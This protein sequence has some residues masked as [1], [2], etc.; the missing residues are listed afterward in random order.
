M[1]KILFQIILFFCLLIPTQSQEIFHKSSR[2]SAFL[3]VTINSNVELTEKKDIEYKEN[4]IQQLKNFNENLHNLNTITVAT[5]SKEEIKVTDFY[6]TNQIIKAY[7]GNWLNLFIAGLVTWLM[8]LLE[9]PTIL[10][11]GFYNKPI[12]S[13][14]HSFTEAVI[15]FITIYLLLTL[16]FNQKFIEILSLFKLFG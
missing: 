12:R 7:K 10:K 9:L 6:A 13:E 3:D 5:I 1:K 11:Y 14:I 4:I 16:M 2:D 15:S 8:C